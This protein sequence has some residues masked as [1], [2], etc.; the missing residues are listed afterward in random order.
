MGDRFTCALTEYG[1]IV[2]WGDFHHWWT[3]ELQAAGGAD[4]R[5]RYTAIG[6]GEHRVCA[7][8]EAGEAVCQGD[9]DYS[10]G[11]YRGE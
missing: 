11:V 9:S 7:V 3:D 10:E 2:C 8:T 6:I 1:E 5:I 4:T